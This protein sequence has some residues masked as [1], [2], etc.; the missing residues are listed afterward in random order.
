MSPRIDGQQSWWTLSTCVNLICT[1]IL[2]QYEILIVMQAYVQRDPQGYHLKRVIRDI[3]AF[4]PLLP[5]SLI[6]LRSHSTADMATQ[7]ILAAQICAAPPQQT[8]SRKP[9]P[10]NRRATSAPEQ[11]RQD[12]PEPLLP[13]EAYCNCP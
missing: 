1:E 10:L 9:A 4:S 11:P 12:Q 5:S 6:F 7:S 13:F 3:A 2:G 8:P